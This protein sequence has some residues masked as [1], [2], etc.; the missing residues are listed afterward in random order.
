MIA[1]TPADIDVT[2]P[3]VPGTGSN[4]IE[5]P[6]EA[7]V[8]RRV[9]S[10][11]AVGL[12]L[13]IGYTMMR[14]SGW[15]GSSQL[16]TLMEG[17]ATLLALIVGAM[18]LMR[19]YS[20]KNNTFLFIGTG[21]LG[22]A[23]LDGYHAV[24]TS[25]FFA[26]YLPS[27]LSSL[28]PWSWVASRLFLSV[29]L[30]LSWLAWTREQRLGV[31]G[32]ISERAVYLI[33]GALTVA[34]F[35]FFAFVPLPRAYYPEIVF[36]R[37]EEFVPALFFLVALVGYLRK[38]KWRRDTFEHWLVLALI[39]GFVG[40]AVFMS[41]SGR[42]FDLEFDAA[43]LLKKVSYVCVLIGLLS[44]MY[45]MFRRAEEDRDSLQREVEER[46]R[47]EAAVGRSE[48]KL[49]AV[50]AAVADAIIT[51]DREGTVNSFNPGAE[52]IFGYRAGEVVGRNIKMLM[53]DDDARAH[54]GH[55]TRYRGTG[56]S[57]VVGARRVLLGLRQDGNTFPMDL[58]ISEMTIGGRRMFTGIIRDITKLKKAEERLRRKQNRL[59]ESEARLQAILDYSPAKIHIKDAAGHYTV[60]N[61]E[62]ARLFGLSREE[63]IGKTA[64]EIFSKEMAD[65]FSDNDAAVLKHG[66]TAEQEGE[67]DTENGNRTYLTV[68]F[69]ILNAIGQVEAVG[70]VGTDI[71]ELKRTEDELLTHRD[72]LENLVVERTAELERR[73]DQL[74]QA[75]TKERE[76]N[77]LQRQFVSMVSHEFRTPLAIIDA[78]AQ[79]IVRLK[80][81]LT[82]DDIQRRTGDV[83]SAVKRMTMLIES[84]LSVARLDAGAIAMR[85]DTVDLTGAIAVVCKRQREINPT[86]QISIDV[87]GITTPIL[88]DP[89]MLDQ[90]FTNLLSNAIKYSP[91][92]S[93]IEVKGWMEGEHV[94]VSVRDYGLGIPD[95]DLPRMCERFFRAGTSTGIAGTGIGLHLV[96][97]LV[98]M[99]GGSIAV[100]SVEGDGSTFTVRLPIKPAKNIS[101]PDAAGPATPVAA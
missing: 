67:W 61:R 10:Y 58:V 44:N 23:L 73:S 47:A 25:V 69:P 27:E 59:Q 49:R 38:G 74:E 34:S 14:G 29:L 75:L 13:V 4:P 101:A 98:E 18:A 86:R 6:I 76:L 81:R 46:R 65:R 99:H 1:S 70:S 16:H 88:A 71:T 68:K 30:C 9:L 62:A 66:L 45:S 8:K 93:P 92:D 17:V 87:G 41:Y 15:Q 48:Q 54:D 26:S 11:W 2:A 35:V 55:I 64:R 42:L 80:D 7:T 31:A 53:P 60:V 43:H 63:I 91:D 37:P 96:K 12:G 78:A 83:R 79:R 89:A 94:V 84:S 85:P 77:E 20:K 50:F 56:A 39:V 19:F 51:T 40:Q 22:T 33:T 90:V 95:K 36:H 52:R 3:S 100:E 24:V 32:R 28:I 97:Q 21:F 57:S 72:H 82:P 5:A